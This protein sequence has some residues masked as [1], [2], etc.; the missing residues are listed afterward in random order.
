MTESG[1]FEFIRDQ[2]VEDY[3]SSER[4]ALAC[5]STPQSLVLNETQVEVDPTSLSDS[6][7][8]SLYA[9]QPYAV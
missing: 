9:S 1:D 8:A 4:N 3:Y 7:Y 6:L 5:E 2:Y